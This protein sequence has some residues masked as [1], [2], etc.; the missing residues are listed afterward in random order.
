MPLM[1][2]LGAAPVGAPCV[3]VGDE[4]GQAVAHFKPECAVV[5]RPGSSSLTLQKLKLNNYYPQVYISVGTNGYL[6]PKLGPNLFT[7]RKKFT[8]SKVTWI[9]P[10]TAKAQQAVYKTAVYFHDNIVY[11]SK[12]RPKG[13]LRSKDYKTVAKQL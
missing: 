4:I 10:R 6:N 11:L 7:I 8:K 1:M 5:T 9:A 13:Q 2:L 12:V 3:F